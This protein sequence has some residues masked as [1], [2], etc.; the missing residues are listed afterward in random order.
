L[1]L[2]DGYQVSSGP[3]PPP[4]TWLYH[5]HGLLQVRNM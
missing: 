1:G 4:S 3:L 2:G 5:A